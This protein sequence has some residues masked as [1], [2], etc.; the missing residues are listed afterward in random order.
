MLNKYVPL[1]TLLG[2]VTVM[3]AKAEP[4]RRE[5]EFGMI[6]IVTPGAAGDRL[7]VMFTLPAK[8]FREERSIR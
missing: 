4:V 1:T 5:I 7:V 6:S 3:W 8:L 2:T